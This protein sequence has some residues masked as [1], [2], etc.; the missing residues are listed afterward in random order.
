MVLQPNRVGAAGCQVHSRQVHTKRPLAPIIHH[1]RIIEVEPVAVGALHANPLHR[2]AGGDGHAPGPADRVPVSRYPTRRRVDGPVEVH[3]AVGTDRCGR[4]L[5]SRIVEVLAPKRG[6]NGEVRGVGAARAGR[7]PHRHRRAELAANPIEDGDG[8]DPGAAVVSHPRLS[9]IGADHCHRADA[10]REGKCAA[11]IAEQDDRLPRRIERQPAMRRVPVPVGGAIG[12][13]V[14]MLE[15]PELELGAEH[16]AHRGVDHRLRD[17]PAPEGGQVR[18]V[19]RVVRLKDHVE[20]RRQRVLCRGRGARF[21]MLQHGGAGGGRLIGDDE[22]AET[23]LVP[24]HVGQEPVVLRRRDAVH[25]VVRAHHRL[26]VRLP[27]GR[28]ERRKEPFCQNSTVEID[29]IAVASPFAHVGDE[30]FGRGDH[31]RPLERADERVAHA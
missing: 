4:A 27:D 18:P 30:M 2:S 1:Q 7:V 28:A 23:P 20:P 16:A 11:L 26:R 24:E 21:G 19:L 3:R 22:P 25:R 17:P 29:R 6:G 9:G 8:F 31:A 10:V 15:Q 5:E 13:G 12:I 14:G